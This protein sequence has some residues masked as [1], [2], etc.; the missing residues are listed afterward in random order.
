MSLNSVIIDGL[1]QIPLVLVKPQLGNGCSS[2]PPID[3]TG[4]D[5][6]GLPMG[7]LWIRRAYLRCSS[8]LAKVV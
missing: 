3:G 5:M 6:D 7:P 8:S 4:M 1:S 2:H